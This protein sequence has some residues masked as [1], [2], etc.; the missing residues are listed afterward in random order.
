MNH[1]PARFARV[2]PLSN[3]QRADLLR[4]IDA[5]EMAA[6]QA[7]HTSL[8]G[9]PLLL[10]TRPRAVPVLRMVNTRHERAV[11]EP[12]P[13]KSRHEASVCGFGTC[14]I[15][16]A[17]TKGCRYREAAQALR[18]EPLTGTLEDLPF[19]R[20]VGARSVVAVVLMLVLGWALIGGLLSTIAYLAAKG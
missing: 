20:P 2:R 1:A 9:D 5:A 19:P 13:F 18:E 4:R 11:A 6:M 8:A 7:T 17:C 3:S 15:S 12:V 10:D 14:A 16:P